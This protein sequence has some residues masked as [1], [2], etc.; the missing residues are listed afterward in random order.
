MN[1]FSRSCTECGKMHDTGVQNMVSG[2]MESRTQKCYDCIMCN[3]YS[4]KDFTDPYEWDKESED[5]FK[6][7]KRVQQQI[8]ANL[9]LK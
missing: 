2:E 1:E 8:V 5:L 7:L 9:Y 4:I 6:E 3:G